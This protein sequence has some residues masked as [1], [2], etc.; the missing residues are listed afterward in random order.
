MV[1]SS[2]L[3]GDSS[4]IVI[5]ITLINKNIIIYSFKK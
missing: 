4:K 5:D 1:G 2:N 3:F